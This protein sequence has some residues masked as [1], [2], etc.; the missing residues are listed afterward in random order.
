MVGRRLCGTTRVD[1]EH[2]GQFHAVDRV[3]GEEVRLPDSGDAN[4][5]YPHI[6]H[7]RAAYR[8]PIRASLERK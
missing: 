2:P 3:D 6:C 1:V 7:F 8:Q 5:R 4:D